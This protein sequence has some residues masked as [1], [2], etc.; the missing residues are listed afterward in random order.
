MLIARSLRTILRRVHKECPAIH[1]A[2]GAKYL[3]NG[4]GDWN[5]TS[6]PL[7]PMQMWILLQ[8]LDAKALPGKSLA[9]YNAKLYCYAL[10]VAVELPEF[11][12][13]VDAD[14]RLNSLLIERRFRGVV[15]VP[16]P[17]LSASSDLPSPAVQDFRASIA[18]PASPRDAQC[19]PNP[20]SA[21]CARAIAE[22]RAR[23]HPDRL[24]ARRSCDLVPR[25]DPLIPQ[26]PLSFLEMRRSRH[27][28]PEASERALRESDGCGTRGRPRSC[29]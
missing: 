21:P 18:W 5:R 15:R 20:S 24:V 11:T 22:T 27:Q 14:E 25:A 26:A 9:K 4:R 7:H 23:R 19:Q 2:T 29:A 28:H 17:A 10:G 16:P 13:V 6:D 1:E 3:I 12:K 8:A